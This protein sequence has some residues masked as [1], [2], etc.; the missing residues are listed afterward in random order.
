M[1]ALG[2]C[3]LQS[4]VPSPCSIEVYRCMDSAEAWLVEH[5]VNEW[6]RATFPELAVG[7]SRGLCLQLWG[8]G[9][10]RTNG[11]RLLTDVWNGNALA[12]FRVERTRSD[13]AGTPLWHGWRERAATSEQAKP[14]PEF[15]HL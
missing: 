9:A 7:L 5:G 14:Q 10:G 4:Q 8:R 13:E 12:M 6:V 1:N 11:A 15:P 2:S 3:K